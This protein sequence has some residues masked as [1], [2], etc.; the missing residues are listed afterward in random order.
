[1]EKVNF[2]AAG[3]QGIM[4]E[5]GTKIQVETNKTI[6]AMV[7]RLQQRKEV[8]EMIPTFCSL[9][10]LYDCRKTS[11]EQM[12]KLLLQE[13]A[14][15]KED[16]M[17]RKTVHKIPVC[18][19]RKYGEDLPFVAAYTGFDEEEVIA[20]HSGREYFIYML[21]FLP[22]FA[23]LG[24]MDQRLICPRLESP[25][26]KIPA[27]SVGIGG[28]Q[29]GIY[30]LASPGGWRLIGRTPMRPYQPGGSPTILF[31]MGEYIRFEPISSEEYSDIAWKVEQGTYHHQI[32][33]YE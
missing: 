20:L 6:R 26:V 12:K 23:Y 5:F 15:I 13:V 9:L 25:R 1:M 22:G 4:M 7:D 3:D 16:R 33:R 10:I 11:Y 30:P 27:G 24:G 29:T 19:E 28:E 14:C 18:Y 31:Q 32:L 8:V 2:S 17:R 21:G